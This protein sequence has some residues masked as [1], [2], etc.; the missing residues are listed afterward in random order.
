MTDTD[1]LHIL[2][3]AQAVYPAVGGGGAYHVHALSRDQAAMG[4]DVTVLTT[5]SD[6]DSPH[7]ETRDG[8]TVVRFD[9]MA[10]PL[11]NALSVGLARYLRDAVAGV[12]VVHA[13]S[14]LYA[15]TNVAAVCR[16]V[17]ETLGGR[18][19]ARRPLAITN[20]GLYSQ[21]AP[22][23]LFDLYLRTL[24]RWT[25]DQADVVFCY[26][27]ADRKRLASVGVD[28][29]VAV[30]PNGVDTTRF[31]PDGPVHETVAAGDPSLLF[32]GRLVEGKR[33]AQ[34]VRLARRLAA[35]YPECQLTV[36]GDGPLREELEAMAG[37]ETVFLGEVPYD[38]MPGVF[39]AADTF[40]LPSRAEGT[41]RTVLEALASAT[42][43]ACSDLPHLRAAFGDSVRYF[44]GEDVD[45]MVATVEAAL[46]GDSGE[47]HSIDSSSVTDWN[48]T[49]GR[50][51]SVLGDLV[52]GG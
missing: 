6:P 47:A 46:D 24:G 15:A 11:G 13:H 33:P 45:D 12:D 32:V 44:D 39:R 28:S 1:T 7:L 40:V 3:V 48:E 34:S 35:T 10:K 26:T 21:T 16:W 22:E 14:H 52:D 43:V 36:C 25:L 37:P 5:R 4:H 38:E 18:V 19:C 30:V 31:T 20:H 51:T 42:P 17:S 9:P 2:R 27:E 41:P 29:P 23:R 8:Y 50:T 49:V